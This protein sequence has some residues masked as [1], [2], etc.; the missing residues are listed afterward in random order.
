MFRPPRTLGLLSSIGK[1]AAEIPA[2]DGKTDLK[3]RTGSTARRTVRA[4]EEAHE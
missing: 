1:I 2:M 3:H 4:N